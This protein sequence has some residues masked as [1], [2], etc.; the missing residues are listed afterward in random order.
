MTTPD[1]PPKRAKRFKIRYIVYAAILLILG[2]ICLIP[3]GRKHFRE[4]VWSCLPAPSPHRLSVPGDPSERGTAVG[5]KFKWEIKLL[6]K[7]YIRAFASPADFP[8]YLQ[9]A[10][11][12]FER[13]PKRWS[14]E[15]EAMAKAADVESDVLKLG[16]T[17]LDLGLNA[18]GCRQIHAAGPDGFYH[19][20]NLDW[21]NLGGVGNY[22]VSIIRSDSQSGRLKTVHI[23]FPGLVGA[24][25]IINEKGIAMSFNQLGVHRGKESLY[26]VFIAIRDIAETSPDFATAR[27]RIKVMPYGMPF[28][29]GLSSATERKTAIFERS[30]SGTEVFERPGENH[31]ATADN[32]AWSDKRTGEIDKIVRETPI[33]GPQDIMILLRNPRIMLDCNI[34]SVI[35]DFDHNVFYLASGKVPAAA[36]VY[37]LFPLF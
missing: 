1:T 18:S 24:L 23:T 10:H 30:S 26:P 3:N 14:D 13:I 29:I 21:D 36:G 34:Y 28:C 35:F 11:A 7:I 17:F 6:D 33:N 22:L 2:L 12:M 9:Q 32:M 15:V 31:I 20:H 37:R 4:A 5:G 25:D 16:N 8:R 19:S 27:E